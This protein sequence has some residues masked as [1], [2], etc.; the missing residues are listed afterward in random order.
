MQQIPP[1]VRSQ[2][3]NDVEYLQT[4]G[5]MYNALGQPQQAMVFL[6]RVQQHYAIQHSAAPADVDVQD[7]WLLFNGGNDAGLYRQLMLLGGRQDL[8]DEQR[9]TVQT[10]WTNWA[11]RRANQAAANGNVRRSLAILNAA[12]K[13]FPDNPGVLRALA[14][15]YARAGLPKQAVA[16]FKSQDMTA[17]SASDYKSAVGAASAG[18]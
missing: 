14:A 12:A 16:I 1:A 10:I 18:R 11:V 9:R 17:A 5:A 3:E 4:V 13:S 15:G 8:S 7:A 6:N 2:L